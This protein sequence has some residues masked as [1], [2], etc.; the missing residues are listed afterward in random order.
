[1]KKQITNQEI[2][3]RIS[4]L[5]DLMQSHQI[6][7]YIIPTTDYHGSE[8]VNEYFKSRQFMSGF[9]GSAGTLVVTSDCAWLW[10]DGRYFIQA[11][12][13]LEGTGIE[14]MKMGEEGVPSIAEFLHS[15]STSA[16]DFTIGFD[17]RIISAKDALEYVKGC[18]FCDIDLV[19]ELWLERPALTSNGTYPLYLDVTG[20]TSQ[21]KLERVR[22][23][24][25]EVGADYHLITSLEEIAWLNNLRGSDIDYTPV[26]YA[27]QLISK[28][29]SKLYLLSNETYDNIYKDLEHL[30]GSILL[31]PEKASY[32]LY[33]S[34]SS[35]I[36]EGRDP[37]QLMMA[38]KNPVEIQATK[39]AH[40][41]DG[42]AMVNFIYW[43]KASIGVL[44]ISEISAADYLE[45]LR[46]K[47]TGFKDLSFETISAYG[48]HGAIVHYAPN[49]ESNVKLQSAGFLL[50]DSGAHYS[51]GTTDITRTIA[52]GPLSDEMKTHYTAVL[53]AH[54]AL[55][56][57]KFSK[58]TTGADLDKIAREPLH[59]I[60]LDF[61]H[62]TGHGVGHVL[63]VHEGPQTIS[64]RGGDQ[65]FLPGMITS[66]EPGVYLEGK[67]GIRLEN[68]I[69]CVPEDDTLAFETITLC[70]FDK[71]AINFEELTSE[72]LI[73]LKDYHKKVYDLLSPHLDE[74]PRQ[75]LMEQT[76][77]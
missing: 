60:G 1:M 41:K 65:V 44:P 59:R 46:K 58:D 55:A 11:S 33:M 39:N 21:S 26:F 49:F 3:N 29:E 28:T 9:T 12:A 61:K 63:S 45:L 27:F 36:I 17:G 32:R 30:D 75:W 24:M 47:Q 31:D 7:A 66:N 37:A 72:E 38:I 35:H 77:L 42:I 20:E 15:L 48:S 8:Y 64:P 34:A 22:E 14:L 71:E 52:L 76:I 40:L 54:I 51:D 73:W 4:A 74:H 50:V 5:Q 25:Q 6:D 56:T 43:L 57:A 53:K 62:G 16:S 67:Y 70:P 23:K 10:T 2:Y 68:E 19:D 13:Q 69:L 18:A